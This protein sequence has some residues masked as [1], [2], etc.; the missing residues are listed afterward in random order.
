M[1][2]FNFDKA[3]QDAQKDLT[4]RNLFLILLGSSGN[5]KSYAQGTFG[6]KTLYLYTQGESHGPRSAASMGSTNI[7]PV[8]IDRDGEKELS[9]DEAIKRLHAILDDVAGIKKAGIKAIAIDGATE[10]EAIIR[11]TTKFKEQ[12]VKPFTDG[13]VELA[14]FRQ[15]LNRLK[16]IQ[17]EL[18]VHICMT[19]ILTAKEI[20]EDGMINESTPQLH[21]FQVATGLIQQFDDVMVIG[22]MQKDDKVAYRLQLVAGV[23]K[24]TVDFKTKE[25]KKTFNFSPR[26]TGVDITSLGATLKADLA[27]LAKLKAGK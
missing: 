21:G 23:A 27:E 4:N 9:P 11:E 25:V 13:P 1:S 24:N 26:L 15:I 20:G 5:G 10:L 7:V 17:R 3:L 6:V 12:T 16:T 8:C 2:G 19:C 14:M 22:R 18:D